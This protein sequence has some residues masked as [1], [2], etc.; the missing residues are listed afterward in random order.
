MVFS[1][2]ARNPRRTI[3]RAL[4]LVIAFVGVF[5]GLSTWVI[6]GAIGIDKIRPPRPPTPPGSIFD[7]AQAAPDQR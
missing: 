3:P 7:L 4:Y 6:G 2:E 5:Y 1:E